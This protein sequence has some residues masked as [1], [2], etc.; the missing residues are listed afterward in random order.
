[1]G[2]SNQ[3]AV[4]GLTPTNRLRMWCLLCFRH[5]SSRPLRNVL[6]RHHVPALTSTRVNNY[7]ISFYTLDD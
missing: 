7:M 1:M 3:I 4:T 5:T 2:T 6:H